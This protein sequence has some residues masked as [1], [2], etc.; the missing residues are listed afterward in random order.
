MRIK[1][2]GRTRFG[3]LELL[4]FHHKEGGR[5][6]WEC[7]CDC[8]SPHIAEVG[9]VR[10]G[11]TRS[12]GCSKNSSPARTHGMT[13]TPEYK[14][15][16]G[17]KS[18]CLNPSNKKYPEYGGR[19]IAVCQRWIDSFEA[20]FEDMGVKP[21][22]QYSIGRKENDGNYE[23]DNC[24]WETPKQQ[25]NNRRRAKLNRTEEYRNN[26]SAKL[27]GIKRSTETRARMV[28]AWKLRREKARAA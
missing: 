28:Q 16:S 17:M 22:A 15:W 19:G 5:Y 4:R 6:F 21:G 7:R 13:E 12:C 2:P 18:R 27:R 24:G 1:E 8:G 10:S 3:K 9:L 26:I 20:F 11:N 23:P 25:A 14:S